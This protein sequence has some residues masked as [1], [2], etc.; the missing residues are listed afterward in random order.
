[1]VDNSLRDLSAVPCVAYIKSTS[2]SEPV[3]TFWESCIM[4]QKV[5]ASLSFRA[6]TLIFPRVKFPDVVQ[7]PWVLRSCIRRNRARLREN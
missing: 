7:K 3:G 2:V 4:M 6:E 5:T 1:M